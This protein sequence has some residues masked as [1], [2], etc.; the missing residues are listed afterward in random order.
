MDIYFTHCLWSNI[1]LPKLFQL[2][3]LGALSV[4]SCAPLTYPHHCSEYFLI[5]WYYKMLQ[6]YLESFL[7]QP[8]NQ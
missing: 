5:L 3:P 7:P 4:G 8:H 1:S 2:W 6:A